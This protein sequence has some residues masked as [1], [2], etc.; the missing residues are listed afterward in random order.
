MVNISIWT[1]ISNSR[2]NKNELH[3][4]I[5]WDFSIHPL[6]LKERDFKKIHLNMNDSISTL[7]NIDKNKI[8]TETYFAIEYI[9]QEINKIISDPNN[10]YKLNAFNYT[11]ISIQKATNI[12]L[13]KLKVSKNIWE[14]LLYHKVALTESK[15][16]NY[17]LK[18]DSLTDPL[19]KLYNRRLVDSKLD[20]LINEFERTWQ[21]F[22]IF[23]ID[24]DFFKNINDTFWH[25]MWDEVLKWISKI[26]KENLRKSDI[27]SR[28]WW[29]EFLVILKW[30]THEIALQKAEWIRKEI[31]KSL[32]HSI[33][34]SSNLDKFCLNK[35]W[36]KSIE[37]CQQNNLM[38]F[39][40]QITCSIWVAT[41][42]NNNNWE[43][44][45]KSHI[46][47]RADSALYYAKETWRNKVCS[48][49][50]SEIPKK[51]D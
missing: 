6:F 39:P 20:E 13:K 7:N 36:C 30:T 12:I 38:C 14:I 31:E 48:W 25:D 15:S 3:P 50:W 33:M 46:M 44:E 34:N 32:I 17:N 43:S 26:L 24:I 1:N 45:S 51:E 41:I 16:R 8:N 37:K 42:N 5:W 40:R 27:A 4:E 28:W 47:K 23:I 9:N 18:K 29:E 2:N 11:D 22:S 49:K 19:T 35:K 10:R 21:F